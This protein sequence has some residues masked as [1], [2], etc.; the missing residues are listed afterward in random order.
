MDDD[1]SFMGTRTA[2]EHNPVIA[3]GLLLAAGWVA[4]VGMQVVA[5]GKGFELGDWVG[6]H[7]LG[8]LVGLL[9]MFVFLLLLIVILGELG[10]PDPA[11]DEWPPE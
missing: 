1:T 4:L 5:L 7:G 6:R 10:E 2:I 11:P 9:V 8:G 3:F